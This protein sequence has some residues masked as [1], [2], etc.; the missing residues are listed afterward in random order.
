MSD[1]KLLRGNN[2]IIFADPEAVE[3]WAEPTVAELNKFFRFGT[4]EENMIYDVS[5]ATID[6]YTLGMTDPNTDTTRTICDV[7]NV[8]T[9]TDDTYEGSFTFLRDESLTDSGIF[10][11]AYMLIAGPDLRY[12]VI[13]RVGVP[14]GEPFAVGQTISMF[15]FTTD[16]PVDVITDN[17]P[18]QVTAGLKATGNLHI[19]YTLEA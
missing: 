3:N 9:P 4:A 14:Q 16:Y 6:G 10:N 7:S 11:M 2:S 19:N 5:C 13:E 12:W 15:E 18:I 8:E 17:T 1:V